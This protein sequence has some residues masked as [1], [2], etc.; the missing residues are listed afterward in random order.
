MKLWN[1][2]SFVKKYKDP[3]VTKIEAPKLNF[4]QKA[5]DVFT[6][7]VG[8]W[9]FIIGIMI[10]IVAWAILN[11]LAMIYHWDPYPFILLNLALSCI[12]ALQAPI[13]L[14]SQNRT[15]EID[16]VRAEYDYQVN[17]KAEKEIQDMQRDFEQVKS[18]I[19]ELHE[20]HHNTI[21]NKSKQT[22]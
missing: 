7:W 14:M 10:I 9:S 21:A 22:R 13:I 4:G 17:I 6:S 15:A 11:T 3:S 2:F 8:S 5:A 18:M 16:R 1:F 20:H 12:A 19:K